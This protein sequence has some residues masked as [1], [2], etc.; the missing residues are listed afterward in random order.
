MTPVNVHVVHYARAILVVMC[1]V[2][3][4]T[5][6]TADTLQPIVA[7]D[8]FHLNYLLLN[9]VATWRMTM[10][11]DE[12]V[13]AG[14]AV[15]EIDDPISPTQLSGCS[16]LIVT[17]PQSTGDY[18]IAELSA[19][20]SFA[21]AGG[22][23]LLC[24][25]YTLQAQPLANSLGFTLH[26][27]TATDATHNAD[28]YDRWVTLTGSCIASHPVTA[29][30]STLQCYSTSTLA[31]SANVTPL[32][33][34]DSDA[35]PPST[36]VAQA[37]VYGAGR[38][39]ACG[40][41]LYLADPVPRR[42]I[43]G[44]RYADML[45][46]TAADNRRFVYNAITWLA[47]AAARPLVT[48]SL[49][50]SVG[51]S[52]DIIDVSGTV[53]DACLVSYVLEYRPVSGAGAWTQ[54]GPVHTSSVV[55]GKLGEWNLTGV[56]PGDYTL[57]VTAGNIVGNSSSASAIVH[58]A[59]NVDRIANVA[60]TPDGA[61]V[62]LV[63]KEVTI[64]SDDLVGRIYIEE[65]DRSSG[66]CV[67]TDAEALRGTLATI[68]GVHNVSGASH[69][70][71]AVSISTRP[72][73]FGGP[74]KPI[75]MA[76]G[77]I[78]ELNT[79]ATPVGLLIKTWGVVV[80]ANADGFTIADGSPV[81]LEVLTGYARSHISLPTAGSTVAVVGAGATYQGGPA[82]IAREAVQILAKP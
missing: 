78:R 5:C 45:G 23:V 49:S 38:V 29:G 40:S 74:L 13:A 20:Q 42:D 19:I 51:A 14:Y 17:T 53:C 69:T 34:T 67:L 46:L 3:V 16:V 32:A 22:G 37:R 4:C 35:V 47:G 82:L 68:T 28:G 73:Q 61:Y 41:P 65:G 7:V 1:T 21:A 79:G 11:R 80:D 57:R 75:G 62:K 55:N 9:P 43:G 64:G 8:E 15:R 12:L 18:D 71:A 50:K 26:N 6:C 24:S 54:I 31:S 66:I 81:P 56:A 63:D 33:T 77:A 70:I 27:N 36:A 76:N 72:R 39:V 59:T 60:R 58:V 10:L 2:V 30:V 48:M 52:G 44:G 25:N